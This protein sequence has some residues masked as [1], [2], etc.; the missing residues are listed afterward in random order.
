[1]MRRDI[2]TVLLSLSLV[3]AAVSCCR[4]PW[5]VFPDMPGSPDQ[6]YMTGTVYGYD[7]YIWECVKG[8]RIVV[9]Q[10][11]AEMSCRKAEMQKVACGRQ[12]PIEKEIERMNM[13]KKPVPDD[14]S[15][16]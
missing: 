12:A 5:K 3:L 13:E 15:W 16:R 1:M 2:L 11:F 9:F 14:L 6:S 8:E 4:R 7:V 10:Y